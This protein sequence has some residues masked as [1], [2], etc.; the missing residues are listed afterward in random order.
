MSDYKFY[1]KIL[2]AFAHVVIGLTLNTTNGKYIYIFLYFAYD[3]LVSY[4]KGTNMWTL[5]TL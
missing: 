2:L 1:E 4:Y 3:K 5:S